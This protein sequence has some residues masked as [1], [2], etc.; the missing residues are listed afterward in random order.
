MTRKLFPNR[1][2][3]IPINLSQTVNTASTFYHESAWLLTTY[4]TV[5]IQ[6]D[7]IEQQARNSREKLIE[8]A[9]LRIRKQGYVA[10]SVGEICADAG[11]TKGTFFHHFKSKEAL[12]EACI[13]QWS[14]L[15]AMLDEHV[16]AGL[17]GA[18]PV[19]KA[20][21]FMDGVIEVLSDPAL[22]KSCLA[23]TIAQEVAQSSPTL[24][25]ATHHCFANAEARFAVILDDA[26][27]SRGLQLDTASLASLWSATLQ[28]SIT[29]CKAS[30]DES[31]IRQNL[32][33]VKGYIVAFLTADLS[34][35]DNQ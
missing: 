19:Q 10:S 11:V 21:G 7:V 5:G 35:P 8:A 25:Q 27:A 34:E 23:G 29:L 17:E 1:V 16:C 2:R 24:R 33:H 30:A 12:G 13:A 22:L 20:M 3:S 6:I 18:D 28:G 31:V 14:Q 9:S 4:H 15:G 26:C 32:T